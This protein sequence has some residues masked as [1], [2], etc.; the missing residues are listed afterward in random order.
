MGLLG[1]KSL[2]SERGWG[3]CR[4]HQLQWGETDGPPRLGLGGRPAGASSGGRDPPAEGPAC[5]LVCHGH[6]EEGQTVEETHVPSK[7][8][9]PVLGSQR[10]QT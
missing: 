6:S 1:A 4:P 2:V 8:K 5:P 3:P 10:T 9:V 7:N